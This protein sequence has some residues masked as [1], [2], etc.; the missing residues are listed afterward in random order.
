MPDSK[1]D[2]KADEEAKKKD[3]PQPAQGADPGGSFSLA[4]DDEADLRPVDLSLLFRLLPYVK[5]YRATLQLALFLVLLRTLTGLAGPKLQGMVLD[6]I[7]GKNL[8]GAMKVAGALVGVQA[9]LFLISWAQGYQLTKLGQW[10]LFDL[11]HDLFRHVE[12]CSPAF[13]Q[14]WPVGRL[15]SRVGNDVENLSELF[16]TGL[17][18]IAGDVATVLG[19]TAVLFATDVRLALVGLCALP[20]LIAIAWGFRTPVRR[21]HRENRRRLARL[22]AFLNERITGARV[23]RAFAAEK[24]D[25]V[26]F[27]AINQHVLAGYKRSI[28]LDGLFN[29]GIFAASSLAV[30][31]L[32]WKGGL[33]LEGGRI[34]PGELF[35][36]LGYVQWLYAPIR[37]IAEKYTLIQKAMASSE[38]IVELLSVPD[39]VP[40]PEEPVRLPTPIRGELALEDVSFA[41]VPGAPPALEHVTLEVKPG[42]TL[43]IVGAT[44]A[45]KST[46]A[47]LVARFWDPITGVVRLDGVD[48]KKLAKR[49]LR[50]HV[51]LVLQD[52]FLFAGT[53]EE[54]IALMPSPLAPADR[55]RVEAAARAVAAHEIIERLGG[56][57]AA[58]EE[59]GATL[60]Q[61]ERQLVSFARA[62]AQ[63]PSVLLL[64]EATASLDPDTEARLQAG[65]K[66]L[67]RGRTAI[68]IAHRLATVREASRIAVL[69]KG[70]LR[71]LGT[72][73]ELVK[74]DGLY[75]RLVELQMG[76][77]LASF[78]SARAHAPASLGTSG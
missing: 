78:D 34:T 25:S 70:T 35:A 5:P 30:A 33:D 42:E 11:R 32:L 59:R 1:A 12:G 63:D 54:N 21:S 15:V 52:V 28:H 50:R 24:E 53:I 55:A 66:A 46:I 76:S 18:T 22:A 8:Q 36:F 43:A 45:G 20:L 74:H 39:E 73:D 51:A 9:V 7:A 77:P 23:V 19:V 14:R 71:E 17:V 13:F 62:L 75:A 44:G 26:R 56:Y 40:D 3:A 60:S 6:A 65:V 4:A 61:G 16:S 38:R 48:V 27:D 49:D 37:D 58:V 2:Q 64:D 67:T 41:Y 29:P 72:H 68:V 31:G 69:H 47:N 10:I 57:G